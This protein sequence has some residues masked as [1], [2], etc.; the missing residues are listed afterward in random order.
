MCDK[1]CAKKLYTAT[2]HPQNN[3]QVERFNRILFDDLQAY[4]SEHPKLWT[5]YKGAMAHA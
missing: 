1:L 5:E 4:V 3:G 2:F